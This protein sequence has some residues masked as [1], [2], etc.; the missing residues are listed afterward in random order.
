MAKQDAKV[1]S[2]LLARIYD[3]AL[4]PGLWNDTV[5]AMRKAVHGEISVLFHWDNTLSVQFA[6]WIGKS[7]W[8]L[9]WLKK[10]EDHFAPLDVRAP[11]ILKLP[12]GSVYV[13]DRDMMLK[14][15]EPSEIFNDFWRPIGVAHGMAMH[16]F[17]DSNRAGC[18]SVH[19]PLRRSGFT[20]EEVALFET[21]APHVT[22]ALQLHR[23]MSLLKMERDAANQ[24]VGALGM[25]LILVARS[26]KL[27]FANPA[28][29]RLLRQGDAI[30]AD[31][32]SLRANGAARTA[33]LLA[34]IDQ[35]VDIAAGRGAAHGEV[36]RLERAGGAPVAVLVC[37]LRPSDRVFGAGQPA[38]LVLVNDPD[39]GG[40]VSP[41]SL[42]TL[43]GLT[44]AEAALAVALLEGERLADFAERRGVAL[45]T[46][47]TQLQHVFA[48]IGRNRQS[49]LIRDLMTNPVL[50]L[51]Q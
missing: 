45:A 11:A 15:V 51:A 42:V 5:D 48:K 44:A 12:V 46:V 50:R 27:F 37:P 1:V 16:L 30:A 25:G 43:Y 7:G 31:R 38:A 32:G 29:E 21:L 22:R 18:L 4:E 20:A 47:K 49:D 8:E 10:Y 28:A 35:A 34:L 33:A 26:G 2:D 41:A 13:N 24:T 39:S 3:A 9:S 6:G 19:K 17:S 23:Q 40:A 14:E 36:L